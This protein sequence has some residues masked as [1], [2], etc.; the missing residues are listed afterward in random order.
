MKLSILLSIICYAESFA[1]HQAKAR[2][3]S[4]LS[5]TTERVALVPPVSTAE[6]MKMDGSTAKS[7]EE[8]VQKTYG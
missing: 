3:S 6:M 7:Y 2:F 1:P 5:S 8:H 4:E